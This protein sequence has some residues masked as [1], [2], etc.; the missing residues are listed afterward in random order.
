MAQSAELVIG[1]ISRCTPQCHCPRKRFTKP[2]RPCLNC[3]RAGRLFIKDPDEDNAE[4]C[5]QAGG[6]G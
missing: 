2:T 4:E 5:D 6:G 3:I 1:H